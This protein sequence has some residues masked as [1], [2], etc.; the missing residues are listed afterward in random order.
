MLFRSDDAEKLIFEL[1]NKLPS[2]EH[3]I[4]RSFLLL[5]DIY[6]AKGNIFQAKHTLRSLIDNYSG[7]ELVE[8][9]K[10]KL[11]IIEQNEVKQ[12]NNDSIINE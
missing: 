9:A 1:I 5:S 7:V 10:T 8:M 2:Y 3:W 12:N 11:A 6:V 4:A